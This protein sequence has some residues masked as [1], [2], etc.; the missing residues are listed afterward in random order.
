MDLAI[1]TENFKDI[2]ITLGVA[3]GGTILGIKKIMKQYTKDDLD[4]TKSKAE[5]GVIELIYERLQELEKINRALT[6]E[7]ESLREENMQT[8][9]QNEEMRAEIQKLKKYIELNFTPTYE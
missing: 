1:I 5:K 3:L 8:R 4:Q 7:L 6:V 9:N 2:A